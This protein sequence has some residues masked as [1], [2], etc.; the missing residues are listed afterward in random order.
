M[1][2]K[3]LKK[4]VRERMSRTGETYSTARMRILNKLNANDGEAENPCPECIVDCDPHENPF[5]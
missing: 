5:H 1:S 3:K 4:A 2:N